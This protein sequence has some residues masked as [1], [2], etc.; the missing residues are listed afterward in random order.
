MF[1]ISAKAKC[2]KEGRTE[3]TCLLAGLVPEDGKYM[4]MS[5]DGED[6]NLEAHAYRQPR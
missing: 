4:K 5:G 6:C 2:P 1:N 3:R